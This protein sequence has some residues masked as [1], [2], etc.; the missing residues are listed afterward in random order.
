MRTNLNVPDSDT[1][2]ACGLHAALTVP[3]Q[4]RENEWEGT[5]LF[6]LVPAH[7]SSPLISGYQEQPDSLATKQVGLGAVLA[8]WSATSPGWT[9][10]MLACS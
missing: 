5:D 4:E 10:A 1:G 8:D 6:E 3:R 2:G 9:R 7:D